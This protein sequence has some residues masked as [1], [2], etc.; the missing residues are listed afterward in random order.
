MFSHVFA[1]KGSPKT[2]DGKWIEED[3]WL[4]EHHEDYDASYQQTDME[5]EEHVEHEYRE[6]STR[7]SKNY[8]KKRRP[9][10][11]ERCTGKNMPGRSVHTST[12]TRWVTTSPKLKTLVNR[13]SDKSVY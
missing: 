1:I 11:M 7:G 9:P 8:V 5:E 4:R 3:A 6:S 2:G 12:S 13:T 10:C